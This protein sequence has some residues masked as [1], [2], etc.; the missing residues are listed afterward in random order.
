MACPG[1]R[2]SAPRTA[3]A[4]SDH[5]PRPES[6]LAPGVDSTPS[7][8]AGD[9]VAEASTFAAGAV[10][11]NEHLLEFEAV[12]EEFVVTPTLAKLLVK[13]ARRHLKWEV[14]QASRRPSEEQ[15]A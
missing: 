9:T 3:E 6:I 8:V 12:S 7:A 10:D 15:A 4:D 14:R 11:A 5:N 2:N 13:L 1:C